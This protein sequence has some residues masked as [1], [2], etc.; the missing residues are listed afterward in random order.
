[1]LWNTSLT[2]CFYSQKQKSVLCTGEFRSTMSWNTH[3][4]SLSHTPSPFS[5]TFPSLT[6]L[7]LSHTPSPLSRTFPPSSYLSGKVW[8]RGNPL[9]HFAYPA[10]AG[11]RVRARRGLGLNTRHI[12]LVCVGSMLGHAGLINWE[13]NLVI[14]YKYGVHIPYADAQY[15]PHLSKSRI[16]SPQTR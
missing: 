12:W 15:M 3:Q 16:T 6:H 5:H 11:R 1:M 7:P 2:Y 8:K 4:L 13:R 14:C 10:C 9:G